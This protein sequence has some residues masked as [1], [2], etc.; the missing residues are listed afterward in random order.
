MK[1]VRN[2]GAN[3]G[4][5]GVFWVNC[6]KEGTEE[7]AAEEDEEEDKSLLDKAKEKITDELFGES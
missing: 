4:S 3:T 1:S 7:E 6:F 5:P 2:F